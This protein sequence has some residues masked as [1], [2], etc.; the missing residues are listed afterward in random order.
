MNFNELFEA[1]MKQF[2]AGGMAENL[3]YE[4]A[5]KVKPVGMPLI[6]SETASKNVNGWWQY[7]DKNGQARTASMSIKKHQND[8][9]VACYIGDKGSTQEY[10]EANDFPHTF[11]KWNFK[12]N[13]K[14]GQLEEISKYISKAI[15]ADMDGK[16]I[17][18]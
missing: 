2:K 6:K 13:A 18:E 10:D 11:K 1:T 17:R 9:C 12:V 16:T 8:L 4:I 5:Y 15:K 3:A 14:E 7:E